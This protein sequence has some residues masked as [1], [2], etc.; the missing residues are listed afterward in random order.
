V[1]RKN[2]TTDIQWDEK[3]NWLN[4]KKH[5][6][7]FEEAVTIFSDPLEITID[8]PEHALSEYRFISLGQSLLGR[9]LVVS[10]AEFGDRI[11]LISA[12]KPTRRERVAYEE[13]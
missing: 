2:S 8:D 12:R 4:V 3:K 13:N 10:Y 6:I 1:R 9:L 5:G 11:R 7:S